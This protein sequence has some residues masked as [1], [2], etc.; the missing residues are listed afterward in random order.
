MTVTFN[1]HYG[2][3]ARDE[4]VSAMNVTRVD[5]RWV[6]VIHLKYCNTPMMIEVESHLAGIELIRDVFSVDLGD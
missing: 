6:V 4:D 5:G 3:A 1:K 2:F